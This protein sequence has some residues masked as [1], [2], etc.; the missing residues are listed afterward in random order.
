MST[1]IKNLRVV[2]TGKVQGVF[3]RAST[4]KVADIIG[5]RGYVMNQADGSVYV[6]AEGD[7]DMVNKLIDYC[8]H[9]PDTA[10]VEKVSITLG[11]VVGYDGFEIR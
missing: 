5:V 8:H 10:K 11:V 7:D 4:K 1:E 2:V 6:E 9:G 3:F